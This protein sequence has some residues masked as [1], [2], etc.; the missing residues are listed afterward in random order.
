MSEGKSYND[1]NK[2]LA[3][4]ER[5]IRSMASHPSNPNYTVSSVKGV[6]VTSGG[7]KPQVRV[8]STFGMGQSQTLSYTEFPA[9]GDPRFRAI[10]A[11]ML[12][13]HISKS[14]DYG[15]GADI[16]A[17]YRSAESIGIPAWKSCFIRA[18]EKVQRLT[19]A[20]SGKQLNHES[21]TDSFVDLANHIVISKV[22][23]DEEQAKKCGNPDCDC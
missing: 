9:G 6:T 3:S 21:V 20:F 10:L 11:E 13:T 19:N 5:R 14:S 16:Y 8:L 12:R 22:L 2:F 15:T 23:Y 18:L 1:I 7:E 17:N 4:E